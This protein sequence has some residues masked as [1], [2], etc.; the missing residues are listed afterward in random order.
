[1]SGGIN[2]NTLNQEKAFLLTS[3]EQLDIMTKLDIVGI[4]D[5]E[6]KEHLHVEFMETLKQNRDGR[7]IAS[8]PWKRDILGL[9]NNKQ[10]ALCRLKKNTERLEKM[11]IIEEYHELMKEQ[12]SERIL[13]DVH[14]PPSGY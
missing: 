9:P 1:M 13:E 7:Y 6:S 8:L 3:E 2:L 5:Q 12:I 4:T 11:N 14:T 10:L